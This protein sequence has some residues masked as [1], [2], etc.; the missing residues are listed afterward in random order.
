MTS[1]TPSVATVINQAAASVIPFDPVGRVDAH[2]SGLSTIKGTL[3]LGDFGK[4][5]DNVLAWVLPTLQSVV[6]EPQ[7]TVINL[8]HSPPRDPKVRTFG[9]VT[10]GNTNTPFA[11][12]GKFNDL[13]Q[14]I[15]R[16]LPGG[17]TG[18]GLGTFSL[19]TGRVRVNA[20]V[21][22]FTFALDGDRDRDL[23]PAWRRGV[24][25]L[26]DGDQPHVRVPRSACAA[27]HQRRL[28]LGSVDR[29]H[30]ARRQPL[31]HAHQR[32]QRRALKAREPR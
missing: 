26:G 5:S 21:N 23:R 19:A 6:I 17:W 25:L 9:T 20:P 16:F 7:V 29:R 13:A 10:A 27:I 1:T 28:R 31:R 8:N 2:Q 11:L 12:S 4:A 22:D 32:R 18:S 14:A 24:R 30:D 15:D 3:D